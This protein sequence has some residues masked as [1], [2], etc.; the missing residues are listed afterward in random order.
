MNKEFIMEHPIT[1]FL[2][3]SLVCATFVNISTV[4]VRPL[5]TIAGAYAE[6][7]REN[8]KEKTK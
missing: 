6:K 2:M 4:F 8:K 3:L 1:G 7:V 5:E